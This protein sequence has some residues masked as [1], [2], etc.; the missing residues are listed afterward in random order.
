QL[1]F[2]ERSFQ[3]FRSGGIRRAAGEAIARPPLGPRTPSA[4]SGGPQS[5]AAGV[6]PVSMS[7]AASSLFRS[8]KSRV[9]PRQG[10]IVL[11]FLNH[12]GLIAGDVEV[13]AEVELASDEARALRDAIITVAH[14]SPVHG[15]P[16]DLASRPGTPDL[17]SVLESRGFGPVLQR[18]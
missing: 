1:E 6:P 8:G 10:L 17:R 15:A 18:L 12:P 13:L 5:Q 3:F 2:R 4:R 11:L 9:S 7:L 14:A 16:G